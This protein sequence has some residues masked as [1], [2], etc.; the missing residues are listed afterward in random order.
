MSWL[1][2]WLFESNTTVKEMATSLGVPLKTVYRW[3]AGRLPATS[4]IPRIEMVTGRSIQS[5]IPELF[6]PVD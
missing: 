2:R 1:E 4:I 6:N 5:L 3:K